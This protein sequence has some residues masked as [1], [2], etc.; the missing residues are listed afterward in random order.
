[1]PISVS[2][3]ALSSQLVV[4]VAGGVPVFDV[5]RSCKLDVATTSGLNDNQSVKACIS[6]ENR[7]RQLLGGDWSK[8][9]ASSKAQCIP[10]ENIGGTPS[11]V[12]LRTC[13][14]MN[15]WVQTK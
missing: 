9:S 13:L 14:Q 6:D 1:M 12:S 15:V 10:Q 3:I 11:Y 4:A 5:A 8:F 2:M 7:A